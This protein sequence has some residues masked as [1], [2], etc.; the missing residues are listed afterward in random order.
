MPLLQSLSK[1]AVDVFSPEGNYIYLI[2]LCDWHLS[3]R[4]IIRIFIKQGSILRVKPYL[5]A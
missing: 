5:S 3:A 4:R 2:R 1:Q